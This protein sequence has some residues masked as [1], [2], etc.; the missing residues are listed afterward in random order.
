VA[1]TGKRLEEY[2]KVLYQF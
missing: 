2:R 1:S